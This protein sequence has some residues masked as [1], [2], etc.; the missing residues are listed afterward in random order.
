VPAPERKN[1]LITAKSRKGGHACIAGFIQWKEKEPWQWIR[2]VDPMNNDAIR[3]DFLML[4]D[5]TGF[6]IRELKI[7][8]VVSVPIKCIAKKSHQ[9]ENY[10]IHRD[11]PFLETRWQLVR[12]FYD[13][14]DG[15]RMTEHQR[16]IVKEQISTISSSTSL[17]W[18]NHSSVNGQNDR[19][20]AQETHLIQYS[21]AL[22]KA[23][24]DISKNRYGKL[25]GSFFFDGVSYRLKITDL[26]FER[27]LSEMKIN[28]TQTIKDAYLCLSLGEEYKGYFYKLIAGIFTMND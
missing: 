3:H 27:N 19:V 9:P 25:V 17:N 11:G 20:N 8:D 2:P 18:P 6:A 14:N 15:K 1:V 21:L 28:T 22:I 12:S 5:E 7:L 23:D 10:Q 26:S 4:T 16:D 24:L 13:G